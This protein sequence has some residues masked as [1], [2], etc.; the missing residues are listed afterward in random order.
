MAVW[1]DGTRMA[2]LPGRAEMFET[3]ST[4]A[5]CQDPTLAPEQT[6]LLFDYLV[7]NGEQS[8]R[9]GGAERLRCL[10]VDG[11]RVPVRLL[12][13]QVAR[14]CTLEDAIDVSCRLP[15]LVDQLGDGAV[16]HQA[17]VLGEIRIGADRRQ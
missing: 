3:D 13:G 5:S 16:T 4:G 6:A 10:E 15:V 9:H 11:E 12:D 17:G 14:L 7:G 1:A 8:G 2:G